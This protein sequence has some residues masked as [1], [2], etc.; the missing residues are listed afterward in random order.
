MKAQAFLE[1]V[2]KVLTAQADYYAARKKGVGVIT[3]RNLLIKSKEL[4]KQAWTV[5][6]EGSL[7]PDYTLEINNVADF[8]RRVWEMRRA[9]KKY[10]TSLD[11]MDSV[12]AAS[13]EAIVDKAMIGLDLSGNERPTD[14]KGERN[15][16]ATNQ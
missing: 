8:I 1:L 6:K 16:E 5:V 7:E 12:A 15:D 13:L 11:M 4:E 9:Q 10:R 2:R 3:E 14:G